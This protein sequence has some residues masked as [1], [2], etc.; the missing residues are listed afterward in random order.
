MSAAQYAYESLLFPGAFIAAVCTG[1]D[2][3]EPPGPMPVY[4]EVLSPQ[5]MADL[6][7]YLLEPGRQP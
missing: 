7:S 1:D 2:P 6:I 5:E 4:G 3:C